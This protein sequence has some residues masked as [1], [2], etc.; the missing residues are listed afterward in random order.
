VKGIVLNLTHFPSGKFS[1]ET[2]NRPVADGDRHQILSKP[3]FGKYFTDHMVAI[4]WTLDKGWHAPRIIPYGPLILNPASLVL[5]YG[6]A[7]FEG[8]K[9][10]Q[11]ADGSIWAFR[12]ELNA[13]RFAKSA[14]RLGLPELPKELF[15]QSIQQLVCMDSKWLSQTPETSLY[16]RPFMIAN[17]SFLGVR[18]AEKV[19]FY[20]I[21]S[22]AGPYFENGVSSVP[23]WV[24]THHTRAAKGGTGYAKCAGNYA[25]SLAPLQEARQ[26]GC[27]QV[28]F[29]DAEHGQ[30]LEEL[31]GMNI[32]IVCKDGSLVTP[33]LSDSILA[34]VTRQ[35]IIE[36]ARAEGRRVEERQ[37][38]LEEVRTG[39]ASG[40]V[41][42]LFAC[43]TAAVIF[44]IS[45]L[46]G[47]NFEY[48]SPN[49]GPANVSLS[50]RQK[51]TDIQYGRVKNSS[52]WMR[53]LSSAHN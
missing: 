17:E 14:G 10:Y 5:H 18:G 7:I 50:L 6:Q 23:I 8:L 27:A 21:A 12:A 52:N 43:G 29:L 19:A 25:G 9:A 35:S 44:P 1:I 15:F 20:V 34:G 26:N 37:I 31:G 36:I 28:L 51:L 16:L 22:P 48:S 45:I 4:D 11:H 49:A 42:E 47:L 30:Y 40:E 39:L 13:A 53:Q 33:A 32:F 2:S 46:K 41:T 38:G 3:G 24:S